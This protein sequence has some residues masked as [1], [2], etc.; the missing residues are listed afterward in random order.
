MGVLVTVIIIA[1][2]I[3]YIFFWKPINTKE[4]FDSTPIIIAHRGTLTDIPENTLESFST[5]ATAAGVHM[6]LAKPVDFGHL[7][8]VVNRLMAASKGN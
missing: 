4:I 2:G 5:A 8:A 6:V 3:R 1:I 7:V